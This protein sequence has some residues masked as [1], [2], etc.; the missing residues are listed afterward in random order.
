MGKVNSTE[1]LEN[2]HLKKAAPSDHPS[3]IS[4]PSAVLAHIHRAKKLNQISVVLV[5]LAIL[6]FIGLG[7]MASLS[8]F[9]DSQLL[10]Q[11]F[12]YF[13]YGCVSL[14]IPFVVYQAFI[15]FRYRLSQPSMIAFCM[16]VASLL[17]VV[18]IFVAGFAWLAMSAWIGIIFLFKANL[19]RFYQFFQ[20]LPHAQKNN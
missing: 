2:E 15:L 4:F 17:S 13:P 11:L 16:M 20:Q 1:H 8:Q 9:H 10:Y 14:S 7:T 6:S 18:G 19:K 3:G 5:Y 12:H